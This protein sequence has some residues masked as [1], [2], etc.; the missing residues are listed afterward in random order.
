[1]TNFNL[2]KSPCLAILLAGCCAALS[3]ASLAQS[4]FTDQDWSAFGGMDTNAVIFAT[5]TDDA[6]NLYIG[7]HFSHVGGVAANNIAKWDGQ[8]WSALGSGVSYEG[9]DT[10][11]YALA[12]SGT[13][14]YAGGW[15]TAA[16]GST[17]LGIAKWDGSAWSALGGGLDNG[18]AALLV[19]GTNLY[20]GGAFT[21]AGTTPAN[22]IAR[23]D[24]TAW[25][26]L[27]AGMNNFVHVLAALGTNLYAGGQFTT[28]DETTVNYVARWDGSAWH[29]L[30]NDI[31]PAPGVSGNVYALA[32]QG[33]N[34]YVGGAFSQ[35][36]G[37][38]NTPHIARWNGREWWEVYPGV[39]NTVFALGVSGTNLY[40]GGA[41]TRSGPIIIGLSVNYI[42]KWDGNTWSALGSG[43]NDWVMALAVRGDNLYAGGYFTNAGGHY[44]CALARARIAPAPPPRPASFAAITPGSTGTQ[45]CLTLTAEP[46]AAFDLLS[47]TNLANWE[48]NSILYAAGATNSFWIN[49]TRPREFYRLREIR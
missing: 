37:Y 21:M 26:N 10:I 24:G 7:G 29:R 17:A 18:A 13:N 27:G 19:R 42:A 6:G 49:H 12:V 43:L 36:G 11:V 45:T 9:G 1:M 14:L 3:S 34:L 2:T 33:T 44:T 47:S 30:Q 23:W 25:H 22:Y 41:F 32:V 15:F 5:V 38:Y 8:A 39:N 40:V 16:G 46:G 20:V 28:A 31:E 48:F 4:T 35:A